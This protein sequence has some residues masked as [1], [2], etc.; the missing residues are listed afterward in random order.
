MPGLS[1]ETGQLDNSSQIT[2]VKYNGSQGLSAQ[3]PWGFDYDPEQHPIL[4]TIASPA[5]AVLH[6]W[7]DQGWYGLRRAT[8]TAS[9]WPVLLCD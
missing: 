1:G 7:R 9:T 2:Y 3:L 6:V 5:G 8:A 4:D